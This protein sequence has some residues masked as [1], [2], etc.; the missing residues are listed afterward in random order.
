[1]HTAQ[2]A[3][4]QSDGNPWRRSLLHKSTSSHVSRDVSKPPTR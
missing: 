2:T 1:V 3:R 4:R